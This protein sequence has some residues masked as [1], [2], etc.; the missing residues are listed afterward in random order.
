VDYT[1]FITNK[2]GGSAYEAVLS[3]TLQDEKGNKV[4]NEVWELGEI[5]PNEEITITY[6]VVFQKHAKPGSYLNNAQVEAANATSNTAKIEVFVKAQSES[7]IPA[8]ALEGSVPLLSAHEAQ[9]SAEDSETL[10]ASTIKFEYEEQP[11]LASVAGLMQGYGGWLAVFAAGAA[12]LLSLL[13]R[14]RFS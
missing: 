9:A 5:L 12:L 13:L 4:N 10:G 1:V 11:F 7:L 2:N 3:D 6:T 14:K 8:I